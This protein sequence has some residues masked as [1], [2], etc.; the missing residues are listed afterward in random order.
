VAPS[1]PKGTFVRRWA[2]EHNCASEGVVEFPMQN[3]MTK[4][5]N[6]IISF[7]AGLP[8]AFG[9][10]GAVGDRSMKEPMRWLTE[11]S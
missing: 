10:E 7:L 2:S 8:G 1:S 9:L 5:P 6:S 11:D 3:V 4:S